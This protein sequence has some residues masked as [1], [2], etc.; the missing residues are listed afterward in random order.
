MWDAGALAVG[1]NP[2][3]FPHSHGWLQPQ[4]TRAAPQCQQ[5]EAKGPTELW[6][7]R[8]SKDNSFA[9]SLTKKNEQCFTPIISSEY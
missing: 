7:C 6:L 9:K 8:R 1:A 5:G 2:P 3:S 4:P